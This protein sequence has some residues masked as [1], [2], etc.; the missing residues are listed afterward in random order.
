MVAFSDII[1]FLLR[2]LSDETARADFE[3][4]P[5]ASLR[6]ILFRDSMPGFQLK[7]GERVIAHGR[8]TIYP[9]RG[10]LQF[11]VDFVRPEGVG[12]QAAKFEELRLRLERE[13]RLEE[14]S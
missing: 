7:D 5:Q 11:V 13:G 9:Q 2:L 14:Q 4:D 1:D 3:K 6:T 8:I 10:E 12:L